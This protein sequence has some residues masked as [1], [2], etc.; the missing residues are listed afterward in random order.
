M[1]GH[2]TPVIVRARLAGGVG[3]GVPWGISLDGLLASEI[4]AEAKAAARTADVDYPVFDRSVVPDE[5]ELPLARCSGAG[6]EFWHWAA[7]FAWPEGEVAGPHVQ[8][9][10]GRPD[11]LALAQTAAALLALVSE[12]QGRYR[13]RVMPLPLTMCKSL[14]WRAVGDP[15]AIAGLLEHITA[16]GKKRG[17]GHGHILEWS[18]TPQAGG[19]PFDY[20]HLH[21]DR[22]L[23]RTVPRKCIE[24]RCSIRTGGQG[25]MGLRPPYMH[26]ARRAFVELPFR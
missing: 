2:G 15:D 13:A 19:D 10:S 9:W 18:V 21:P 1:I 12:R 25:R 6:G 24:G 17:A 26:P 14:V 4:R 7:T 3:H 16:I 5:L 23:G 20:A 8:Y 11:Q 22:S